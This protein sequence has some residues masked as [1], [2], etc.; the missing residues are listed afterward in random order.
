MV[1]QWIFLPF[2]LILFG[3]IPAT[4]SQTRLMFG[5]YLGFW[6]TPKIRK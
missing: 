6:V 4:E 5:K 2:V 3:S 1:L